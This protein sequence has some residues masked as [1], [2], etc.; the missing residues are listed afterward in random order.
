MT[1]SI[2]QK[3]GKSSRKARLT[4]ARLFA[5][6]A[7]Y[8][9]LQLKVPPVSLLDE[10]L[11]HRVGMDLHEGD[12]MVVP[13]GTLFTDILKGVTDRWDDVMQ[14]IAPRLTN[15]AMEPL[16]TAILVCGT[17]E[18]LAQGETDTPIII[19]DYLHVTHGFF[20]GSESK[21]VNGVLDAL[22]KELRS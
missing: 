4:A 3:A 9:S 14:L 8:Q 22:A 16:L 11:Q 1:E 20:A 7:V 2:K 13:D 12:E 21:L 10:Y 5:V 19:A 6:Q 18:L 15:T 17:Y